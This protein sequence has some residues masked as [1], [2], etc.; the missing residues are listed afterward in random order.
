MLATLFALGCVFSVFCGLG[1]AQLCYMMFLYI[2][3]CENQLRKKQN[4]GIYE[5]AK[6]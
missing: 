2:S 6:Y 4:V 5:K 1:F 3:I